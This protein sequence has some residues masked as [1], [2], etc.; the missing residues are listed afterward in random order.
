MRGRICRGLRWGCG[1][2]LVRLF[3]FSFFSFDVVCTPCMFSSGSGRSSVFDKRTCLRG[4]RFCLCVLRLA[5]ITARR[6]A[7]VAGVSGSRLLLV[8]HGTDAVEG[9]FICMQCIVSVASQLNN[10]CETDAV[11][12]HHFQYIRENQWASSK[13][14]M[15]N[16]APDHSVSRTPK[17]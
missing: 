16:P 8:Q 3:F 4:A 10:V 1:E 9:L 6:R 2:A 15:R 5:G 12:Q 13:Y 14:Q 11:Q 17:L 7:M